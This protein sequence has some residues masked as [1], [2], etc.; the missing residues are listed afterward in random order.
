M[1]LDGK[2]GGGNQQR[3]PTEAELRRTVEDIAKSYH[4]GGPFVRLVMDN[5]VSSFLA[6][7]VA[8]EGKRENLA[9]YYVQCKKKYTP[10][11]R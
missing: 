4:R 7:W 8:D 1:T 5:G 11:R 3:R 10:A 2:F 6:E 9:A